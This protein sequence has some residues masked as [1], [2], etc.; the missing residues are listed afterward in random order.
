MK[1]PEYDAVSK[2]KRQAESGNPDG[3]VKTLE[4]YL[5][6][7]PANTTARIQLARTLVYDKKDMEGGIAQMEMVL[8]QEPD[9]IDA[10]KA[11]VT[12]QIKHKR[13]N[14]RTAEIYEKLIEVCPEAVVFNAYA[15]FLRLQKA[16]FKRS[17]EYY[18]KAIALDPK[19]PEYHQN[20]SV[21]LLNDLRDYEKAKREL[22]ILLK[23]DPE[24]EKARKNYDLL[25]KKK[26]DSN[27]N[28][29]KKSFL[30]R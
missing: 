13:Y 10:M 2:A 5:E 21:L 8:K 26:F 1:E 9:N 19:K 18:E 14:K 20:Y 11:L 15:I 6:K 27:G 4:S 25:M 24:N 29:K 16:D 12:V 3:A 7:D 28:V 23:L 22:E 30:R 17:A